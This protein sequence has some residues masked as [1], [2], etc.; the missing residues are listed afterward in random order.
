MAFRIIK[1]V[2][3]GFIAFMIVETELGIGEGMSGLGLVLIALAGLVGYF[4]P[5]RGSG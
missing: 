4:L 1:A 2:L 3:F 5:R